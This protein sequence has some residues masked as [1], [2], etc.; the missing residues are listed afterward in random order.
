MTSLSAGHL[1]ADLSQGAVP[2]LLVFLT[3]TLDLSYTLAAAVVLVATF[4]SSIVQPAF[5][6][7]S[8]SR[9][10]MWLLPTG[11][12]LAGVGI[13]LASVAP[14]Y[15]LLLLA[16]LAAS[17]GVAAFHPEG[18]KFAS[19]VSGSRRASGMAVFS[20]G[21]NLGFALGPIV[22]STLILALGLK[23]GLLLALPGLAAAAYLLS[24]GR[25]IRRFVP[26]SGRR[27]WQGEEKDRP[28]AFTLLLVVVALRSVAHYGLFTFVPLWEVSQGASDRWATRLL[29]LFLLGGVIGTL[30][31]G[32]LADRFGRKPVIV[33]SYAIS[34]PLI[35]VYV[36]VG[37]VVGDVALVA[38]G[39]AVI[40]T[41][42]VTV[43][44]S[45]EYMPSKIGMASGLS[46]G[47]AIG[48]GGIFAVALGGV[49][50]SIDL[51]TAVLATAVGPA[52]GAVLALWLPRQ[53]HARVVEP[54]ATSAAPTT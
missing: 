23:G 54:S 38:A 34:V 26:S 49:A 53:G 6:L 39:A 31:G 16:V 48:L 18:M 44:L 35:I 43:V 30:V 40:G 12:A 10:A 2:A 33:G 7:W 50:D 22:A 13:A 25:Y 21:G 24:E 5:G 3:P 47:F 11:I 15:P 20:V 8:D 1:A 36:L 14:T 19:Y 9:G 51:K 29:S 37:G 28:G 46:V 17:L 42:G 52:L 27:L 45:Q 4:A 41:F 32:P